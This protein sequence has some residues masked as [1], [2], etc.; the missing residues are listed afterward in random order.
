MRVCAPAFVSILVCTV[1]S[2]E[3]LLWH[4]ILSAALQA[5]SSRNKV[6]NSTEHNV[7][8]ILSTR[9]HDLK[10]AT[11]YI[12]FQALS[13]TFFPV[14]PHTGILLALPHL[15]FFNPTHPGAP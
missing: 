2:P 9:H 6:S 3:A 11:A 5:G 4:A 8:L 1:G 14:I 10:L 13:C 7:V 12:S 15:A